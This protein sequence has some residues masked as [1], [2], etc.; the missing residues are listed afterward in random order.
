[1][2]APSAE[3]ASAEGAVFILYSVFPT[4][5]TGAPLSGTWPFGNHI[6]LSYRPALQ[7]W[8]FLSGQQLSIWEHSDEPSPAGQSRHE[9]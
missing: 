8:R 1:M 4:P 7:L 2:A 3:I 5:L 6:S 9:T